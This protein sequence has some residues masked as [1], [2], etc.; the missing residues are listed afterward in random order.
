MDLIV[1]LA[2]GEKITDEYLENELYNI[3]DREHSSCNSECPVYY[4]NGNKV[5]DTVNNF[6]VNRGCDC[7]KSGKNM[8][9][10]IRSKT[11]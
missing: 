2:K 3:C 5:P 9:N 1:R 11:K 8:L 6:S 4:L 7:F 10:F